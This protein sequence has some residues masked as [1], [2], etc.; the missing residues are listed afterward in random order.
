M[1]AVAWVLAASDVATCVACLPVWCCAH[2][3][4]TSRPLQTPAR[5]TPVLDESYSG[6][7]AV[8]VC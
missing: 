7:S 2:L 1:L 5:G 4:Q 8:R 3:E 6:H